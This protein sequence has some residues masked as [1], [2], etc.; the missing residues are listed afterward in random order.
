MVLLLLL[1]LPLPQ[2]LRS[3]FAATHWVPT[4]AVPVAAPPNADDAA[5]VAAIADDAADVATVV[6]CGTTATAIA[7]D[8]A[9]IAATAASTATTVVVDVAAAI[10]AVLPRC[11]GRGPAPI[12]AQALE[13]PP[14][15][16]PPAKVPPVKAPPGLAP[17]P[18]PM[19]KAAPKTPVKAAPKSR[20][21][22]G[23]QTPLPPPPPTPTPTPS[24]VAPQ[25]WRTFSIYTFGCRN[26]AGCVHVRQAATQLRPH[27]ENN[28]APPEDLV[29]Q[30]L[31][32][33]ISEIQDWEPILV[34]DTRDFYESIAV[35]RQGADWGHC[36]LHPG[37]VPVNI[38]SHC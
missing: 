38:N 36:G 33:N 23:G 22:K 15:K 35:I 4:T 3:A 20:P 10:A 30:M 6:S 25:R 34:F 24:P 32:E 14:V 18:P 8:T 12:S 7:D 2:P 5:A 29:R 37:N 9:A 28:T 21:P 13:V 19:A 17:A 11:Y 16:A 1:L 26:V 27:G 31:R